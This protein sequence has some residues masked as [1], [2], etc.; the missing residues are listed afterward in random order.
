MLQWIWKSIKCALC[1]YELIKV[2]FGAKQE[3]MMEGGTER[4]GDGRREKKEQVPK[5]INKREKK[6]RGQIEG[7]GRTRG[8]RVFASK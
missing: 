6:R 2:T 8:G 1:C 7:K 3:E 4:A 5:K